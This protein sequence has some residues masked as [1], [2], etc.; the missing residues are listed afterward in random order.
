MAK[1]PKSAEL[2]GELLETDQAPRDRKF[3]KGHLVAL[4]GA[5]C[6]AV[7]V[8]AVRS[9]EG[10]SNVPYRDI[11]KVW[12]VCDGD[13]K[14][15]VP[16]QAQTDAQCDERL[17]RQLIAHAKPVLECVPGLKD[18]AERAR[19]FCQPGLQHRNRRLL[20]VDRR[21]AVQRRRRPRRVRRLPVLE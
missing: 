13:T 6:C 12:T 2:A 4:L 10:R 20:P 8:P 3:G 14:D 16:G 5:A 17:E 19:R 11:V 18:Q 7:L 1:A 21:A 9:F 15:V